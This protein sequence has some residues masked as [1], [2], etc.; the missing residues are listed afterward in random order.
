MGKPS[1]YGVSPVY[2][3]TQFYLQPAISRLA[4]CRDG[5]IVRGNCGWDE[6]DCIRDGVEMETERVTLCYR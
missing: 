1:Q 4:G 5:N 6:E 3:V 2:A